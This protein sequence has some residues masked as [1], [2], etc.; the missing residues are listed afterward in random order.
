MPSLSDKLKSLGVQ[1]GVNN[2]DTPIRNNKTSSLIDVLG[3]EWQSTPVGDCFVV[4]K[5]LPV[6]LKHGKVSFDQFQKPSI[7]ERLPGLTGISKIPRNKYL[8]IDTETSSL[9]GGTGAYVFLIGAAK[10]MKSNIHFKQFFL[11]DPSSEPAQLA[12]L[13]QFVSSSKVIISYNGKAFDLPR[14]NTRFKLHG[15]PSPFEEIIHVDLLHIARRLWKEHLPT[16]N[17]GEIEYHVLGIERSELDVPGYEISRLFFDYLQS[18]DPAPLRSVFYHNEIDVISLISLYIYI[19][20]RLSDPLGDINEDLVS[21]GSYLA[22]L[23]Y[24]RESIS[25]LEKAISA[26]SLSETQRLKG[27]GDLARLYKQNKEYHKAVPLWTD[28]TSREDS[29]SSYV[30]LAMFYEHHEKDFQEA[31]HWTLSAID[32]LSRSKTTVVS[33]DDLLKL[34]H[35]LS[36]L[37]KKLSKVNESA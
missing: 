19:L 26:S 15:W 35:R 34:N 1:V 32:I 18:G 28:I 33:S 36:R 10:Y 30:E 4:K 17:L 9:S 16:C 6:N 23:N 14:I 2:L 27:M 25:I 24:N 37:K 5:S 7:I 12:A 20:K 29:I 22:Y 21:I 31:I 3:G 11:E 13:E 8:F